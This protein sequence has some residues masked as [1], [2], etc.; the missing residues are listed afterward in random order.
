MVRFV[1]EVRENLRSPV[2]LGAW[3][4]L[5]AVMAMAGPFGSYDHVPFVERALFWAA[6]VAVSIVVAVGVRVL[7]NRTFGWRDY[8]RVAPVTAALVSAIMTLP[9]H[10]ISDVLTRH[11]AYMPP[12]VGEIALFLFC[13]SM[14]LSALRAG[15]EAGPVAGVREL[16]AAL[17]VAAFAPEGQ[18]PESQPPVP[19]PVAPRLIERL[20][21][22][23]R[24]PVVRLSVRD[25][26]V[27]VVTRAGAHSLLMRFSDAMAELAGCEGLQVHRSHWVALAAIS[28]AERRGG[29][30]F[31]TMSD[32]AQV[33]VSRS[34]QARVDALGLASQA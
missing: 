27:D 21:E 20:P 1:S 4:F 8:R 32:G 28:R 14:G 10:A 30:L 29:R 7:V 33:P 11:S 18:V 24:G 13:L 34:Y 9:L 16:P 6:V 2:T 17:V 31:L 5:T 3:V 25:H 23:V 15:I 26:Y 12:A 22:A 19:E